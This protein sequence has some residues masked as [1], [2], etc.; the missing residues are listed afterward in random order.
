MFEGEGCCCLTGPGR[1]QISPA[2]T[3][4]RRFTCAGASAASVLES[5]KQSPQFVQECVCWI[6]IQNKLRLES[7]RL[8]QAEPW[9]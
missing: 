6:E 2:R 4:S 9:P 3:S 7:S 1:E 5:F 8:H